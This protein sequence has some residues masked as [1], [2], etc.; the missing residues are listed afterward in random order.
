[1]EENEKKQVEQSSDENVQSEANVE[2]PSMNKDQ[3]ESLKPLEEVNPIEKKRKFRDIIKSKKVI[4][5]II[6]LFVFII[7][8]VFFVNKYIQESNYEKN[9]KVFYWEASKVVIADSYICEDLRKIWSEFI[10]DDKKYFDEERG[11]FAKNSYLGS[12]C[13]DFSEAINKKLQWNKEK[14]SSKYGNTYRKAK[15][16]YKE[17]TPPP[18]KYKEA[19]VYVRQMFKAMDQLHDLATNPTGNLKSYSNDANEAIK[20][21][22]SASSDLSDEFDF[23]LTPPDED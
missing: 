19:H 1:M 9:L 22:S 12:Y 2:E 15:V 13:S 8:G 14:L 20:L 10:F 16:T 18:S 21:F 11:T 7:V 5:A 23:D 17:M 3:E 6:I 4:M